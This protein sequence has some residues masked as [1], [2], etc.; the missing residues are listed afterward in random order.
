MSGNLATGIPAPIVIL[1]S[2]RQDMFFIIVYCVA[3]PH[4]GTGF[5]LPSETGHF[6]PIPLTTPLYLRGMASSLWL[7][8]H[9]IPIP[10]LPY[11]PRRSSS[12]YTYHRQDRQDKTSLQEVI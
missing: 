8:P 10:H 3:F 2:D 7:P 1:P 6:L 12:V 5:Y 4:G 11:H 9:L